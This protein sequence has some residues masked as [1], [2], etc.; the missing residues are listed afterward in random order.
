VLEEDTQTA[1]SDN[2][3][4]VVYLKK[5]IPKGILTEYFGRIKSITHNLQISEQRLKYDP[6]LDK[7]VLSGTHGYVYF[8]DTYFYAVVSA[9]SKRHLSS[10]KHKLSFMTMTRDRGDAG[11]FRLNR[12]CTY[13][14]ASNIREVAGF[15]ITS[16][17]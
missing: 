12:P 16:I 9:R 1:P 10:I 8:D 15:R 6:K 7:L 2:Y 13:E 11:E 17:K 5:H 3:A 4:T 14:E